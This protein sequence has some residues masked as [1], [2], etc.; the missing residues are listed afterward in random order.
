MLRLGQYGL[1]PVYP[2]G[3]VILSSL[4]EPVQEQFESFR[5]LVPPCISRKEWSSPPFRTGMHTVRRLPSL[6]VV[7]SSTSSVLFASPTSCT[8]SH[9]FSFAE[10]MD[11][12]TTTQLLQGM[13][14][15]CTRSTKLAPMTLRS[16]RRYDTGEA[17]A[18]L[19]LHPPLL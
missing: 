4:V 3:L 5:I 12:A 9:V 14:V 1:C 7:L 11:I 16:C 10:L 6:N 2:P 13:F 18:S 8:P 19:L 15:E 17:E